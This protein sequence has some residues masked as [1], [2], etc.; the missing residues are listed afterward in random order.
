MRSVC[1]VRQVERTKEGNTWISVHTEDLWNER[2]VHLFSSTDTSEGR[3]KEGVTVC[4]TNRKCDILRIA[5]IAT[6]GHAMTS[7]ALC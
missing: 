1:G 6:R 2:C 5:E 3:I 7:E 4:F